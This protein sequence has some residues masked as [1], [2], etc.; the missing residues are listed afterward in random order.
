MERIPVY[1]PTLPSYEKLES[2]I[3]D[4]DKS[5][6]YTNRG[7]LV[8]SL[9]E[10]LAEHLGVSASQVV[11][12]ANATLGLE[13]ALETST[14]L[15]DWACPSWTFAATPLSLMRSRSS[16][17][18][19]DVQLDWRAKIADEL[20]VTN[21]LV[22]VLPFG[23][24]S[25]FEHYPIGMQRVVVDAAASFDSIEKFNQGHLDIPVSMVA[26]LH[27]TK[28]LPGAEGGFFWS[29]DSGWVESF[30]RWIAFGFNGDRSSVQMGTNA[31]MHEYSAALVHAS[32]DSWNTDRSEW[33]DLA[34]WAHEISK[35]HGFK[36][37]P[38][39]VDGF[40]S[41]YWI[42]SGEK[43]KIRQ[44]V[45]IMEDMNVETRQWWGGGC[46]SM[47]A[48]KD[49]RSETLD[50]T[51]EISET[52]IGLPFFRGMSKEQQKHIETA[53]DFLN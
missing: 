4:I 49:I 41:P 45:K 48:F 13:G 33:I 10:R 47:P 29:N 23:S 26:S 12:C 35:V 14:V 22:D 53:F 28:S 5:H 32:L 42:I 9:E 34:G 18:F 51:I 3:R 27:A 39:H 50:N 16:F 44:I 25:R 38:A 21:F 52:S 43:E 6:I 17:Y 40:A 11:M 15:E 37:L 30:R 24:S 19:C 8:R 7:H 36:S 46:H 2:Y 20:G 31:K 1:K